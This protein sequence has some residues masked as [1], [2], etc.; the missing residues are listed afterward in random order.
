MLAQSH[1]LEQRDRVGRE[2]FS[3][4]LAGVDREQD[5]N[6]SAHDM[7]IAVA[8]ERQHRTIPS[9]RA[10]RRR[11]PNLACA[12][13]HLAGLIAVPLV[14]RREAPPQ[15][16]DIKIAV[17]P[18]VE[19]RKIV[20]DFVNGHGFA[21]SASRRRPCISY[22]FNVH[23]IST[24]RHDASFWL[25]IAKPP[26]SFRAIYCRWVWDR[27]CG[28]GRTRCSR[29]A[30]QQEIKSYRKSTR[31]WGTGGTGGSLTQRP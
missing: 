8:H 24:D 30:G 31:A 11:Q 13:L 5:R 27:M 9:V 28:R 2:D 25:M 26:I 20:D 22:I 3:R 1:A 19:Q 12:A 17:I 15:L 21:A 4:A 10:N 14:E 6:Q 23:R 16:D 29:C 7:G 18:I